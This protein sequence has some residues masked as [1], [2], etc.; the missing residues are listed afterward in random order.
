MVSS[1]SSIYIHIAFIIC[2][3][4]AIGWSQN[5]GT[6]DSTTTR[7]PDS[8]QLS[9]DSTFTTD[10]THIDSTAIDS[11]EVMPSRGNL[12]SYRSLKDILN[13]IP[14][15]PLPSKIQ[16][17]YTDSASV[18]N[19]HHF[20]SVREYFTVRHTTSTSADTTDSTSAVDL[21]KVYTVEDTL[22]SS[23]YIRGIPFLQT[24]ID[25]RS[26]YEFDSNQ[27]YK[28]YK[29]SLY[30]RF[31]QQFELV[32]NLRS[33]NIQAVN[34]D[35]AQFFDVYISANNMPVKPGKI[36]RYPLQSRV[37]RHFAWYERTLILIFP[38][39]V[40]GVDVLQSNELV[41]NLVLKGDAGP[42][43]AYNQKY[44][45]NLSSASIPDSTD[46]RKW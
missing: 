25:Y 4:P 22:K 36:I 21:F 2:L 11:P 30:S 42:E 29:D 26:T 35:T 3:I 32:L 37:D 41:L 5:A 31:Y 46:L 1:R 7:L 23:A 27:E 45:L 20:Q 9:T 34:L 44:Q 10:S 6:S 12:P 15:R 8:L 14:Q 13:Q 40:G 38:R 19:A 39:Y 18:L 16:L 28:D 17:T 33:H 24:Q 43:P